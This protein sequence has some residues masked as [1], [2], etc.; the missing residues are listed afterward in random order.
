MDVYIVS[1]VTKNPC[2]LVEEICHMMDG[3]A[4]MKVHT[5]LPTYRDDRY[6]TEDYDTKIAFAFLPA[7]GRGFKL[8]NLPVYIDDRYTCI[9]FSH[10]YEL[11]VIIQK[12]CWRNVWNILRHLM[13]APETVFNGTVVNKPYLPP[14]RVVGIGEDV[15]VDTAGKPALFDNEDVLVTP[16]R[17]YN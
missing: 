1:F 4:G 8:E 11:Y 10:P 15:W 7:T 17:G 6:V 16:L 3:V 9:Y 13:P 14:S 12:N 5:H 2:R